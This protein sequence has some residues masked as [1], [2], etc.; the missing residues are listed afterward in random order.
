[1]R[2]HRDLGVTQKTT[3]RLAHHI[4]EIWA[5]AEGTPFTD[6]VK[7]D[8]TR[9]G[10]KRKDIPKRTAPTKEGRSA[11]SKVAV[12]GA[13]D[14]ATKRVAATDGPALQ[15]FARSTIGAGATVFTDDARAY[16]GV[17]GF[18]HEA[19]NH[20][21]REYMHGMALTNDA[22]SFWAVL[23]RGHQNVRPRD[24]LNRTAGMAWAM[25][26]RRLRYRDLVA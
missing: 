5:K 18:R 24:T 21:I 1:M 3:W 11:A 26:G 9:I 6:P 22:E 10:G 13:K 2:L 19:G 23:K 25:V 4:R 12:A 15:D 7:V 20:S 14:R 8:E 17:I 16:L